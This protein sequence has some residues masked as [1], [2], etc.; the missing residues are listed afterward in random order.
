MIDLNGTRF[1]LSH[2]NIDSRYRVGKY[3]IDISGF[4]KYLDSCGLLCH[5]SQLLIIDEIGKMECF[6]KKFV[7]F[8]KAVLISDK[9]IIAT[10]ASRGGS[11]IEQIKQRQ[12]IWLFELTSAN[13][14]SL[15]S[16]I[17]RK[18]FM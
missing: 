12:D 7:E 6:S 4:E 9:T 8:I 5:S 1:L 16:E 15:P 18:H 10:I 13:R 2:V 17:T 3:G 11:L 14:D